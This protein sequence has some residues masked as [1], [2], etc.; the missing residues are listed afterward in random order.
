MGVEFSAEYQ[1]LLL[2]EKSYTC[3]YYLMKPL[4]LPFFSLTNQPTIH[5]MISLKSNNTTYWRINTRPVFLQRASLNKRNIFEFI[6]ES[7]SKER[8]STKNSIANFRKSCLVPPCVVSAQLN[9]VRLI[10][11]RLV[12]CK[13]Q[14]AG[15]ILDSHL[16]YL[17]WL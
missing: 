14:L 9:S 2:A 3:F 15:A 12:L 13:T 10:S 7:S 16:K 6:S 17:E 11:S 4:K 5:Q 1:I 8:E